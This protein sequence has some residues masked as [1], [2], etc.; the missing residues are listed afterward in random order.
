MKK[1]LKVLKMYDIRTGQVTACFQALLLCFRD[2]ILSWLCVLPPLT[3]QR[4]T[5]RER[6]PK[7]LGAR[8]NRRGVVHKAV[9]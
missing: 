8:S 4:R 9:V 5:G 7:N 3:K 2:I 6:A 1:V